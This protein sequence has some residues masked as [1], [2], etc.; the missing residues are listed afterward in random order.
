M[1]H[2]GHGPAA[3]SNSIETMDSLNYSDFDDTTNSYLQAQSQH[4]QQLLLQQQ[5]QQLQQ[6]QHMH[7]DGSLATAQHFQ[8]QHYQQEDYNNQPNDATSVV[9]EMHLALLYLLSNPEEFQRAL[10]ARPS[11]GATTLH[12]WNAEYEDNESLADT[13]V[14][15]SYSLS[16][17]ETT[18]S[19]YHA[20][21]NNNTTNANTTTPLP[22][23]VFADD[24]EVVLPAAFSASQL[25]GL[26]KVTGMELEA[27]AGLP[28]LSQLFLRW[29]ALMPGTSQFF[30][31]KRRNRTNRAFAHLDA[32]F[33][34][35]SL[36]LF[37]IIIIIIRRR[38][39]EPD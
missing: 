39:L 9:H 21:T 12:E 16:G 29:L 1:N 10:A 6:Q 7:D 33:D 2:N 18:T 20:S 37:G 27:A 19:H 8:Q 15:D 30:S 3:G 5:Q 4:Q 14:T 22:F 13:N 36:S 28:A 17:P 38:S 32:H 31:K 11:R 25:F 35:S 24:A 26:E 23:V 34:F